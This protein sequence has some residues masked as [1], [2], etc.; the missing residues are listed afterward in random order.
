MA[1][2]GRP[3]EEGGHKPLK[4]S[5]NKFVREALEKVGNKS[6]FLEKV[7]QP[8]LEKMDPGDAS[9]FLYQIDV[10]ISRGIINAAQKGDFKQVSALG[11]LANCLEDARKLCEIPPLNLKLPEES[12]SIETVQ[13]RLSEKERELL[14]LDA[15]YYALREEILMDEDEYNSEPPEERARRRQKYRELF[16]LS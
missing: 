1:L 10:Y 7:A 14:L 11:W 3:R 12:L 15:E 13:S 5:L 2:G 6:Q 4:I 9:F 16:K 8:V